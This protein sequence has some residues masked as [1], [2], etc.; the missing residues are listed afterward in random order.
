MGI[1]Q[2]NQIVKTFY[3]FFT[4][5]LFNSLFG[6][7]IL[8]L[9]FFLISCATN[10]SEAKNIYPSHI[11][12]KYS[13]QNY[14]G[15]EQFVKDY[16]SDD[17]KSV[18]SKIPKETDEEFNLIVYSSSK[19]SAGYKLKFDKILLINNKINIYFSDIDPA[20]GSI[21]AA[22]QTHPFCLLKI[23]KLK[24]NDYKIFIDNNKI[25]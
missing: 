16:N 8:S 4:K 25:N 5:K 24:L 7:L 11:F 1:M 19:P 9:S 2:K 14:L 3:L 12:C 6:N 13:S 23:E 10:F 18:I 21:N 15:S 17:F 22:I 20:A